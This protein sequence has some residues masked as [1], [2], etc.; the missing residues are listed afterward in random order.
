MKRHT[1][2]PVSLD[3]TRLLTLCGLAFLFF[4]VTGESCVEEE[5][6]LEVVATVNLVSLYHAEGEN[7]VYSG[8]TTVSV[9]DSV[10]L[11]QIMEDNGFD[12]IKQI[13]IESVHYRVKRTDPNPDRVVTASRFTVREPAG[14]EQELFEIASAEID[15]PELADWQIAP[16]TAAGVGVLNSALERL[17]LFQ[18]ATLT[19]RVEGTSAPVSVPTDF[20]WQARVRLQVIGVRTITVI[21]PI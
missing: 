15:D 9:S 2:I 3:R 5:R 16:L 8:E 12:E 11:Q 18:P 19:F 20:L 6:D 10:D 21:E 1:R 17:R 4:F 14:A 13:T 7:N